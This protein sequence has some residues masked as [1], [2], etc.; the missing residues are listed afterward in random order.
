[1]PWPSLISALRSC[2]AESLKSINS[3][4]LSDKL[5]TMYAP[6]LATPPSAIF[7]PC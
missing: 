3:K 2:G 5:N 1:M 4:K 6:A 7:K